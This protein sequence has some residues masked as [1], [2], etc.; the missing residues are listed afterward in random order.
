MKKIIVVEDNENTKTHY[1]PE[2]IHEV[3]SPLVIEITARAYSTQFKQIPE[4]MQDLSKFASKLCIQKRAELKFLGGNDEH[5][6]IF[7]DGEAY[8]FEETREITIERLYHKLIWL[9]GDFNE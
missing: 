4:T 7:K 8:L 9:L 5:F 6:L 3:E 2:R 1:R